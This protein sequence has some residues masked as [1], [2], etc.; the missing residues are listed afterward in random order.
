MHRLQLV[1]VL[2]GA[3]CALGMMAASAFAVLPD[4][5]I[6]LGGVYPL[7]FVDSLPTAGMSLGSGSGVVFSGTGVS[8]L[9]LAS[10]LSALGSFF[11]QFLSVGQGAKK[12]NTP[13]DAKGVVLISGPFHIVLGPGG[14]P[15]FTNILFLFDTFTT[16]CEGLEVEVRGSVLGT[17]VLASGAEADEYTTA[18][19]M[20]E[21]ENGKQKFTEYK[22]DAG[23]IVKAKL[24]SESGAGFVESDE[25]ITQ[26]ILLTALEGKMFTV[27]SR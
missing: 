10:E 18:L 7:H 2:L 3:L 13:G 1:G 4:I 22:N 26:P 23:T 16:F 27:T 24:E 19:G 9:T 25:N 21:G 15:I 20:L 8:L 14:L 17:Y 11:E 12:C 5:S 6:A